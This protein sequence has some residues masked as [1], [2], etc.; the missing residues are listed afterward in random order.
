MLRV[1]TRNSSRVIFQRSVNITIRLQS[2][3]FSTSIIKSAREGTLNSFIPDV[4]PL[5]QDN[6]IESNVPSETNRLSRTLTKFWEKVHVKY[7]DKLHQYDVQLDGKTLKTPLGFPLSLPESKRHL[8]N[9][10]AHEWANLPDLKVKTHS[11][12]LTSIAARSIDLTMINNQDSVNNEM[13]AKVGNLEDIKLNLLRYFDTDTCLI[14]TTHDE[15]KGTLRKKQDELYL[16]LIKEYED[17]FTVYAKREG[18]LLPSDDSKIELE[19]LDCITDGLRGNKQSITTQNV[20]LHWLNNLPIY[21]LIALER[22]ILTSKS[23]LCGITL[24]RSNVTDKHN[25]QHLYQVNRSNPD[26]YYHKSIDEIIELGNL[27]TIYQT[28][29]WGEVE[30]TH[31]V[32]KVDW[33]RNLTSAAILCH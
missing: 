33:I 18:N 9:L 19:Y 1:A 8:A 31:D 27:E 14:F 25:L 2:N 21:D 29:E 30:D 11:L 22:A 5:G 10:I 7:D 4:K 15:Y 3:F 17:F 23:F 28:A 13:I 26:D 20:V 6:T 12:P 32:D 16:P 24:L